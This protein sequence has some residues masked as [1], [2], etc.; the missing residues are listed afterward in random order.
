MATPRRGVSY[1]FPMYLGD[2]SDPDTFRV[3]PTIAAGDFQISKDGGAFVDLTN[4]P[5]VT[6]S[7]SIRVLISLSATEMTADKIDVVAIDVAGSE[8][9]SLTAFIDAPIINETDTDLRLTLIN[10]ILQNKLTT[11]PDTGVITVFDDDGTTTLLTG[12]LHEDVDETQVYR[13]RGAEV[14]GRLT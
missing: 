8:W 11:D 2:A 12:T 5:V 6:P 1:Q 14:R 13:G 10:K 7:G 4:L 3:N 9:Q